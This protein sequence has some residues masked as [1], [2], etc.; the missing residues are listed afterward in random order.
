VLA[1]ALGV[2]LAPT[3]A[4]AYA[5]MCDE[6]AQTVEA[7]LPIYPSKGG[8]IAAAPNCESDKS[9][10]DAAPER[11]PERPLLSAE[12]I[13]RGLALV[14]NVPAC[15]KSARLA[16]SSTELGRACAGAGSGVFRP[17]RG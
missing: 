1:C 10:L 11:G 7:P 17:P 6:H 4:W 16:L 13:D 3:A 9:G 14:T 5:P 12:S 8:E 15:A 2:L